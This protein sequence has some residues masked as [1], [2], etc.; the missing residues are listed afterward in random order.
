ME[1][2]KFGNSDLMVAPVGLGCYGMSGA[3]GTYDDDQSIATIHRAIELG[4]NLLDTS[5]SY[6]QGH[7]HRTIGKAIKGRRDDVVIHSK[8][9]TIRDANGKSVGEGSGTPERLRK[10]CETSLKNLGIDCLDV[11]TMSRTD[12]MTPTEDS[13]GA[14][15]RLVEE[16]KTRYI[17]LSEAHADT[18]RRGHAVHPLA[19]VQYEYSLWSRDPERLGQIEVVRKLGAAFMAYSPLGYAFLTGQWKKHDDIDP[20]DLRNRL[21]RFAVENFDHNVKLVGHIEDMASQKNT[22]P[23]RIAIAW[24]LTRGDNM[25]PIPGCKTQPHLEDN[26][27]AI[28][29][30]LTVDD[31]KH[32]DDLFPPGAAKGD[33]Y[34]ESSMAR[35]NR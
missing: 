3:Y 10:M 12:S 25:F 16:G 8:T 18:I 24:L 23:A 32:F 22:T 5:A 7:N 34:P 26:L 33:R 21:P 30:E 2:R 6:G 31:L 27:G 15:A 35:V 4:C 28:E 17:G 1:H 14:M 19:S 9:G 11:F 20:D 13:V 29:L